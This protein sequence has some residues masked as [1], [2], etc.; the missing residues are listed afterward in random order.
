M[1]VPEAAGGYQERTYALA[2]AAHR[3]ARGNLIRVKRSSL[4]SATE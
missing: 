1:W 2:R 3:I 4:D